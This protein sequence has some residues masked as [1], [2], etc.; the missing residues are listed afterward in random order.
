MSLTSVQNDHIVSILFDVPAPEMER[1]LWNLSAEELLTL[2][3]QAMQ[4][5]MRQQRILTLVDE[6]LESIGRTS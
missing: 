4:F 3:S 5:V 1:V 2:R 6:R